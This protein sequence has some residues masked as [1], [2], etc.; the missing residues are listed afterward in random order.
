MTGSVTGTVL[1][2]LAHPAFFGAT[3]DLLEQVCHNAKQRNDQTAEGKKERDRLPQGPVAGKTRLIGA[4][5]QG[6]AAG[7]YRE[8]QEGCGKDVEIASH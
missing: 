3:V 8:K 2:A 7:D 6:H 1:G 4:A 5:D